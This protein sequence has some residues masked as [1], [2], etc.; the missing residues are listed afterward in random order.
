MEIKIKYYCG[1]IIKILLTLLAFFSLFLIFLVISVAVSLIN[2]S[3]VLLV[4][5]LL[6]IF[7]AIVLFVILSLKIFK[8]TNYVFNADKIKV[9]EKDKLES[10]IDVNDIETIRYRPFRFRYIITIFL[11]ELKDGGA[12]RLHI[13]LKDGNKIELGSFSKENAKQ[14]KELYGEMFVIN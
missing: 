2:K 4:I 3:D 12:W 8:G 13:T 11:G 14:L 6:S 5:I 9:Y 7:D 1:Y 10:V